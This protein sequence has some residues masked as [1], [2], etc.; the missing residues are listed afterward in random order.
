M[1]RSMGLAAITFLLT[2]FFIPNHPTPLVYVVGVMLGIGF[3]THWVIPFAMMPDVI[4]Y[5]EKMT[6]ERR[7]GMYYGFSNFINKFAVALA[8][9]VSGWSLSW[10]KYVPNA[11]QTEQ[12]LFGIRFFYAVVPAVVMLAFIPLLLRYPITR[13]SHEALRAE[14]RQRKGESIDPPQE[15]NP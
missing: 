1:I 8:T 10:F 15:V 2:F 13:K 7:E 12:T 9:A 5:D 3:S 14:L 4:E 6:G 11:V